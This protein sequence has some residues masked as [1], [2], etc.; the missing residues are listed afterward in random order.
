M[1]G[2][3]LKMKKDDFGFNN[4]ELKIL[5]G[6]NT[7]VKIQDFLNSLKINFEPNG[8]TCM[9]PRQVLRTKK[10]HCIE[11]AL[12]AA[13]ALRM[14]GHKP[15]IV[16]LEATHDDDDHVITVFKKENRWGAITK[17]N[18]AVLRYREPVYRDIRELVLSFFHEYFLNSNGKKTLRTFSKPVDLSRFDKQGWMTSE[19][20]VWFIPEYLTQIKHTKIL[21]KN[22]VKGLRKADPIEIE[23]GKLLEH[24][25]GFFK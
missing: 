8:D 15:L 17:T 20:D 4:E 19:K 23:A 13:T 11:G 24:S 14:H 1:F 16:D 21:N 3:I 9:S 10:A 2:L 12:L 6:L 18:H 7:P 22:L 5:R 25:M